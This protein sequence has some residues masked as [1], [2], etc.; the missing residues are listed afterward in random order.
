METVEFETKV[1]WEGGDIEAVRNKF[2]LINKFKVEK[3]SKELKQ[4]CVVGR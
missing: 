1:G 4:R 2:V 3:V